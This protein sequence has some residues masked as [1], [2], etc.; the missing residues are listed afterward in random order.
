VV[1][2]ELL[3]REVERQA[4][5]R[6]VPPQVAELILE[7]GGTARLNGDLQPV[8]VLYADIRGFTTMSEKMDA[9][10][11]VAMLREFFSNMSA[12]ILDCNGTVDKYI[13]DC[14]MAL[15]GAPIQSSQ[16]VRDGLEAAIYMQRKMRETNETR[17]KRNSAP[18][19]IGIGLHWGRAVVG[20]IG[21]GDRVQYTAIGDTVNVAARLTSKAAPAQIIVSADVRDALPEYSGFDAL[22]EVELKGRAGKLN[23][24]S[25]R[26]ADEAIKLA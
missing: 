4:L 12:V 16:S 17:L 19:Q 14:I 2:R 21:S 20:N 22:G 24:F 7:A 26:W 1:N 18:I 5:K 11:I 8:T 9:R 25:V 13:G 10:E 6:Y 3:D 15:F 23:I